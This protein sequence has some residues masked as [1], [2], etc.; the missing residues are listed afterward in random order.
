M[1]L[2]TYKSIDE[3]KELF[4]T[5]II[6][7]EDNLKN[8]IERLS[9]KECFYRGVNDGSYKMYASSQRLYDSDFRY[10]GYSYKDF[11]ND[12]NEFSLND[13]RLEEFYN[14]QNLSN[15]TIQYGEYTQS[16]NFSENVIWRF[17][18]LQHL[19]IPSP[20]IDFSY[21]IN[22]A[23]FFA[24]YDAELEN[25]TTD[26]NTLSNY[27]QLNCIE[28]N[29]SEK[30]LAS[31]LD[32]KITDTNINF[33]ISNEFK[34]KELFLEY[35]NLCSHHFSEIV[36]I[37]YSVSLKNYSPHPNNFSYDFDFSNPNMKAQ[38]GLL[39]INNNTIDI[40]FEENYN[41]KTKE[42]LTKFLIHK[43]LIP[44][45]EKEYINNDLFPIK[46]WLPTKE[47]FSCEIRKKRNFK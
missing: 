7:N 38:N 47:E 9:K 24:T 14:K 22:V 26:K 46:G 42:K 15:N 39:F 8:A 43:N 32:C 30:D 20:L 35:T 1:N 27:I 4:D 3:I 13:S 5:E 12:L 21:H 37:P 2:E 25:L 11:L 29:K 10:L 44:F 34:I 28:R 17:T 33:C 19:G 16:I 23:L 18:M 40:P 31:Y 45:I 6:T 41:Q 36:H